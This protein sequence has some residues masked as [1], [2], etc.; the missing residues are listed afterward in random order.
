VAEAGLPGGQFVHR[1]KADPAEGIEF[2]VDIPHAHIPEI[3]NPDDAA[4]VVVKYEVVSVKVLMENS[5]PKLRGSSE[6]L[7]VPGSPDLA[8]LA[9]GPSWRGY[10]RPL[11]KAAVRNPLTVDENKTKL[12]LL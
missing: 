5:F 12:S 3:D 6:E 2:P 1:R 7:M 9:L 8:T 10:D 11:D 4:A